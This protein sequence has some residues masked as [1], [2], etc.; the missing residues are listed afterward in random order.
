[1]ESPYLCP[2]EGNQHG[3]HSPVKTSAICFGYW[4]RSDQPCKTLII[5]MNL[6]KLDSTIRYLQRKG[7][8]R[9]EN[10]PENVQVLY[11]DHVKP[12]EQNYPMSL[13]SWLGQSYFFSTNN[14]KI[15]KLV[16]HLTL[17]VGAYA[18]KANCKTG[19]LGFFH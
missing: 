2:A 10:V 4:T 3:G 17:L 16:K 15:D 19:F 13:I 14:N 9:A 7:A 5:H 8:Y 11:C 1:M 6:E 18:K 12:L